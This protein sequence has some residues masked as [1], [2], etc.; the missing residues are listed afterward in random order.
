MGEKENVL[1]HFQR[2]KE[3]MNKSRSH[4]RVLLTELT[5]DSR[6]AIKQLKEKLQV[7]EGILRQAEMCR[8]LETEQ[9]KVLPFYSD[10]ISTTELM[11]A[12]GSEMVLDEG[13]AQPS[14]EQAFATKLDG[15]LIQ[16]QEAME[17]FWK[18]YNKVQLDKLAAQKE[19]DVLEEENQRLRAI[20]KQ[21]LD[22]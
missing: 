13:A 6:H 8:K 21:Y 20:L 5:K 19:H 7:A 14:N 17:N 12:R 2:L 9:E 16:K 11:E 3:R 4:E 18:R 1:L 22:G 10:S 15:S